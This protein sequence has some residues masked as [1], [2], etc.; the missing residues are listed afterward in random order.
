MALKTTP[1]NLYDEALA[2]VEFRDRHLQAVEE[3]ILQAAGPCYRSDMKPA[4]GDVYENISFEYMMNLVPSLAF[5]TPR[6]MLGDHYPA[7]HDEQVADERAALNQVAIDN[8]SGVLLRRLAVDFCFGFGVGMVSMDRAPDYDTR[9]DGFPAMWPKISRVPPRMFIMDPDCAHEDEARWMGIQWQ[10]D[11]DDLLNNSIYDPMA[12]QGMEEDAEPPRARSGQTSKTP[13]RRRVTAFDIFV[14]E[15]RTIYTLAYNP[16]SRDGKAAWLRA[17]RKAFAHR[18]G[19]FVIFGLGIVPDRPFP[20]SAMQAAKPQVDEL[21]A[22]SGQM[23]EDAGTAKRLL[24]YDRGNPELGKKIA[25]TP[26]GHTLGVDGKP[27]DSVMPIEFG[28]PQEAN[29]RYAEMLKERMDRI[30][31]ISETRRGNVD[32]NA[33]ATADAIAEAGTSKRET[34][35]KAVFQEQVGQLFSRALFLLRSTRLAQRGVT[36]D[37]PVSGER[38][39]AIFVGGGRPGGLPAEE[40]T[41]CTVEP[42]SLELTSEQLLQKRSIQNVEMISKVAPMARSF[43]EWNWPQMID[44]HFNAFNVQ[45][46]GGRYLNSEM[47]RMFQAVQGAQMG[48]GGSPQGPP[49]G[50]GRSV[51]PQR[52]EGV[53]AERGGLVPGRNRPR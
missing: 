34:F 5:N 26:N 11:K 3:I 50:G 10:A 36:L 16:S 25:A 43:P 40:E 47:L 51:A 30:L 1:D 39:G 35:T 45:G 44:D 33:T 9:T 42:Y 41:D 46:G 27:S 38:A 49:Q 20:L 8:R 4:L 22:H 14:R 32:P 48:M 24:A 19:P 15:D 2:G 52:N 7:Y 17:P 31:G 23:S 21:N 13:P 18:R 28:G 12:V 6:L 29:L 53:P 37:D